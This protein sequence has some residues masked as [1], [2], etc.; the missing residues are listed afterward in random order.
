MLSLWDMLKSNVEQLAKNGLTDFRPF[1]G[2]KP[3]F[4]EEIT[5]KPLQAADFYA[6]QVRR[7]Y[8]EN[9]WSLFYGNKILVAPHRQELRSVGQLPA[10]TWH[11]GFSEMR[12][13]RLSLLRS[14]AN[15]SAENPN[16]ELKDYQGPKKAQKR[17]RVAKR[18]SGVKAKPS[19]GRP[20]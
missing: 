4:R 5:F 15:H 16:A 7:L 11:L 14:A 19:K 2:S 17:A 1:L 18:A 20:S 10:M 3:I 9:N 8:Y 13:L 12:K 6:W